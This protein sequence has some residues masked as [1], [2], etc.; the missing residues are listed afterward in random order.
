MTTSAVFTLFDNFESNVKAFTL[1]ICAQDIFH[2][3]T[4]IPVVCAGET[5][6][7]E[8]FHTLADMGATEIE[9]FQYDI[10]GREVFST[11]GAR[12]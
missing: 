11:N 4:M 8:H 12:A 7:P 2:P 3:E 6:Y 9:L 5:L 10:F 1:A